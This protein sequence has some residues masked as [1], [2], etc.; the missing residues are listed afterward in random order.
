MCKLTDYSL[1]FKTNKWVKG[2]VLWVVEEV[3]LGGMRENV[4]V[5]WCLSVL[6]SEFL[7]LVSVSKLL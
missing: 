6:E 4:L 1:I 7:A 2:K 3:C 5:N